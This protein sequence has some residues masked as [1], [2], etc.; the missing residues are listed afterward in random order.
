MRT[1]WATATITL[2][3]HL[4]E[5]TK[6]KQ[7]NKPNPNK[8]EVSIAGHRAETCPGAFDLLHPGL[9]VPIRKRDKKKKKEGRKREK[10]V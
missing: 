9:K 5:K 10:I 6:K 3:I 2:C 1:F 7:R 8:K 4:K